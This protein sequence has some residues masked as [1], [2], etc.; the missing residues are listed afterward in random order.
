M[1]KE[2]LAILLTSRLV[3]V[4]LKLCPMIKTMAIN[5]FIILLYYTILLLMFF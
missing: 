5:V 1:I 4:I 3:F 2:G